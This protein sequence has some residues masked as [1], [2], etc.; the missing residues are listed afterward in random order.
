VRP[1]DL[2]IDVGSNQTWDYVVSLQQY[3]NSGS[4][5]VYA[6]SIPLSQTTAYLITG[7]DNSGF[8]LG[9]EIRNDHPYALK[10]LPS[11]IWGSASFSGFVNG[12]VPTFTFGQPIAVGDT[13][14][15][16]WTMNCAN[17]V[18]YENVHTTPAPEP[19]TILLLGFGLIGVGALGKKLKR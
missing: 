6:V 4:Y 17:E 2:F 16:G 14:I 13:F 5:P 11:N 19:T 9:Y 3:P 1:G 8:W 10:S 15:V 12:G 18:I 7:P